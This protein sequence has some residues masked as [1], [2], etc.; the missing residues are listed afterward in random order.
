[1]TA[2]TRRPFEH[3]ADDVLSRLQRA[4]EWYGF[5]GISDDVAEI[6]RLVEDFGEAS[7]IR[8]VRKVAYGD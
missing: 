5:S 6:L 3:T 2:A 8:L 7:L 4:E 1:L